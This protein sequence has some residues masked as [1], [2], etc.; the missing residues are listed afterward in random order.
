[1]QKTALH[2]SQVSGATKCWVN[3]KINRYQS[4]ICLTDRLQGV[5][6]STQPEAAGNLRQVCQIR[7]ICLTKKL[8]A[9]LVPDGKWGEQD[10]AELRAMFN[11][12]KKHE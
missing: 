6:L 12:G 3:R 7:G 1:M 2:P 5:L 10:I 11:A 4:P 9:S 8:V